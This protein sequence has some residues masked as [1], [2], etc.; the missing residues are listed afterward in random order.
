M[1]IGLF[2]HISTC[3]SSNTTRTHLICHRLCAPSLEEGKVEPEITAWACSCTTQ[4]LPSYQVSRD[5]CSFFN[6]QTIITLGNL[7]INQLLLSEQVKHKI[8]DRCRIRD[9]TSFTLKL[10]IFREDDLDSHST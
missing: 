2:F 10:S 5:L 9:S 6:Q 4:M 3:S 1:R 8:V 7:I